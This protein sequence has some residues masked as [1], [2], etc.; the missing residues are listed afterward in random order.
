MLRLGMPGHDPCSITA[1]ALAPRPMLLLVVP[2][3]ASPF[4][5]GLANAVEREA[6]DCGWDVL[7]APTL[8]DQ[9]REMRLLS[10]ARQSETVG[11]LLVTNNPASFDDYPFASPVVALVEPVSG[12]HSVTADFIAMGADAARHLAGYGHRTFALIAG[13]PNAASTKQLAAGFS[14]SAQAKARRPDEILVFAGSHSIAHGYDAV[15]RLASER[16]LATG[17]FAASSVI[18]QGIMRAVAS[19]G[20][21]I[22][23]DLSL[24]CYDGAGPVDLLAPSVSSI[25]FS[26]PDVA[27]R[28]I[29][30]LR[31]GR[32]QRGPSAR[33]VSP[34]TLVG[35]GSSARP[36]Q[37]DL[38]SPGLTGH[39]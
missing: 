10:F 17:I 7:A 4:F 2:D 31:R 39:E 32:F 30:L 21:S 26:L 35:R 38:L 24:V 34:H 14:H 27:S 18:A 15:L 19:I 8:N 22:P 6:H 13:E 33:V 23:R 28:A 36:R 29:Q 5:A 3:L 20:L 9:R 37:F 12:L 16:R 1:G 25:S 11:T